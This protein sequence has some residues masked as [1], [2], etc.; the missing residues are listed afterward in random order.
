[1]SSDIPFYYRCETCGLQG[2]TTKGTPVCAKFKIAINPEEDFCA[3]HQNKDIIGCI[4][5]GINDNL[6]IEEID[7]ENILLCFDHYQALH[8]C[9]GC[10]GMRLFLQFLV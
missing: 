5:C 3:W 1:M 4:F 2:N 7:G 8:S 9:Q 10:F 6:L